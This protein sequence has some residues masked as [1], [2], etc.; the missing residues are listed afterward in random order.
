LLS[1]KRWL[2]TAP[3]PETSGSTLASCQTSGLS[4]AS[5]PAGNLLSDGQLTHTYDAAGR[6]VTT[7][8]PVSGTSTHHYDAF[9]RRVEKHT[10]RGVVRFVYDPQ[11]HMIGE[12]D[13][14]ANVTVQETVWL[15]D[16]P[17]AVLKNG[18][19][20]FVHTDHLNTP[21]A[22]K[23]AS[24]QQ[25]VWRWAGEP[26]GTS[27]AEEDVDGDGVA[28]EYN[29]RFA[30]QYLDKETGLHQNWNRD[31]APGVG[32]Y[33]QS[34]PIGL[35]GG[36]NTYSYAYSSPSTY[37]DADG[38]RPM[39]KWWTD[40]WAPTTQPGNCATAECVA[41]LLP[42]RSENRT[43]DQIDIGQCKLVCQISLWPPVAACNFALGGG[44]PGT[45]LGQIGRQNVCKLVCGK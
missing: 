27:P 42:A 13:Y 11:G 37:T 43:Q 4:L 20:H 5:F 1:V 35:A 14:G 2:A 30:G 22:I 44:L 10:P 28:F 25:T 34:D 8:H 45:A 38:L 29:L 12:Y 40:A 15:G 41:G 24:T 33:T 16:M 31:Y 32:R 7:A 19:T 36:I 26:F 17:V 39:P 6:R 18:Q 21:R 9:G 23:R 3:Q